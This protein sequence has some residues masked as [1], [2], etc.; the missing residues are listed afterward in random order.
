MNHSRQQRAEFGGTLIRISRAWRRQ[1][2]D[3]VRSLGLTEA[4]A[5]PLLYVH[6]AGGGVRQGAVAD[7]IGIEGP[8]LVRLID[9][10]SAAGLIERREDPDDR[11]AKTLHLTA[12]GTI[13]AEQ[14]E[15]MLHDVRAGL[16]AGVTPED[17]QACLRVFHAVTRTI[18]TL[19]PP[20]LR[21]ADAL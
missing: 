6:R 17:L 15:T 7:A 19:P 14:V 11:R 2:D 1:I 10:L 12:A 21:D 16:L 9:Q 5:F 4:T 20:G 13:A 3:A 18:G 8:S